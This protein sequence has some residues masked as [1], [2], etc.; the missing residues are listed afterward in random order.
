MTQQYG[1]YGEEYRLG[2]NT[3]NVVVD[4]GE[5]GEVD[6]SWSAVQTLL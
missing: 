5:G 4:L 3:A 2:E 6:H 1:Q